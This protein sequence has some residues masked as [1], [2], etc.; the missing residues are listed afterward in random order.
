MCGILGWVAWGKANYIE[1]DTGNGQGH[2]EGQGKS[3]TLYLPAS[4]SSTADTLQS[5]APRPSSQQHSGSRSKSS[6]SWSYASCLT[7]WGFIQRYAREFT[8]EVSLT[9]IPL[10]ASLGIVYPVCLYMRP[11]ACRRSTCGCSQRTMILPRT[12]MP[13]NSTIYLVLMVMPDQS[14]DSNCKL[15]CQHIL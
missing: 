8:L 12:P 10:V 14:R 4:C 13:S 3:H 11:W 9:T 5:L 15:L 7:C 1:G 6:H 2:E